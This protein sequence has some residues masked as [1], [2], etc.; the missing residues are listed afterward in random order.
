M[1]VAS[2]FEASM[3]HLGVEP[4]KPHSV[5]IWP[6]K[7]SSSLRTSPCSDS[8]QE[9]TPE[10]GRPSCAMVAFFL[11]LI[12]HP[13]LRSK[14]PISA[15][16]LRSLVRLL[17]GRSR[18]GPGDARF[19]RESSNQEAWN[20]HRE[21]RQ[22]ANTRGHR[23]DCSPGAHGPS[24]GRHSYKER[25]ALER[26][27][28]FD[29]AGHPIANMSSIPDTVHE[30]RPKRASHSSCAPSRSPRASMNG[31]NHIRPSNMGT[32]SPTSPP[33]PSL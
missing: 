10:L 23:M 33:G 30:G 20:A 16:S 26:G 21:S 2:I 31:T 9:L 1:I 11:A 7:P 14:P 8:M 19:R 25:L 4:I 29:P 15:R 3:W 17:I 28:N 5:S 6:A 22:T 24:S 32:L 18:T 13:I 12:P 27:R